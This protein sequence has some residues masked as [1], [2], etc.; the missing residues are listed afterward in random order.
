[1]YPI[2]DDD[3]QMFILPGMEDAED[4]ENEEN[5]PNNNDRD[6]SADDYDDEE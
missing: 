1:M 3:M 2:S 6:C 5:Y 4:E